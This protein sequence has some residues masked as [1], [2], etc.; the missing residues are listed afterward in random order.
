[1][2][3]PTCLGYKLLSLILSIMIIG[4]TLPAVAFAGDGGGEGAYR[5]DE[6]SVAQQ[7]GQSAGPP[8]AL[9][10]EAYAQPEPVQ[11]YAYTPLPQRASAPA[12]GGAAIALASLLPTPS[13]QERSAVLDAQQALGR[14]GAFSGLSAQEAGKIAEAYDVTAGSLYALEEK[15]LPLGQSLLYAQLADHFGF[16]VDEVLLNCA[17]K[18]DGRAAFSELAKYTQFLHS[19]WHGTEADRA[20][21]QSLLAG[22]SLEQ[23]K[24]AYVAS[25]TLDIPIEELLAKEETA[26]VYPENMTDISRE[27]YRLFSR[28]LGI[29]E[30]AL[31][32]YATTHAKTF[33]RMEALIHNGRLFE[34]QLQDPE[35]SREAYEAYVGAIEADR[36][37]RRA[38][39][40][41]EQAEA[42][43]ASKAEM[44]GM[45]F[46]QAEIAAREESRV[47]AMA[48][49]RQGDQGLTGAQPSTA[50]PPPLTQ[51]QNQSQ[52]PGAQTMPLLTAAA[53]AALVDFLL[54]DPYIDD[55]E[56][57][58]NEGQYNVNLSTGSYSLDYVDAVIPGRNGLDLV[59]GRQF[60]SD[61]AYL[62]REIGKHG[63]Y[64]GS[65][66][67][68][69][70]GFLA[71][72]DYGKL[73]P[74][75]DVIYP[76]RAY[77]TYQQAANTYLDVCEPDQYVTVSG[78]TIWYEFFFEITAASSTTLSPNSYSDLTPN[79]HFTDLYGLGNG[80]KFMFS[81]IET[82]GE[83]GYQFLHLA[84]GTVHA[85]D[86]TNY[87]SHLRD[88]H[89]T[90]LYLDTST[91]YSNGAESSFYRLAYKDGKREYFSTSGKLIGVK[92]RF[93]NTIKLVHTRQ[94][95]LPKISITDTLGNL[96]TIY[97]EPI[98]DGHRMR[99]SL[100]Q[101]ELKYEVAEVENL[102][103]D[104]WQLNCFYDQMNNMANNFGY[105]GTYGTTVDI[106]NNKNSTVNHYVQMTNVT[107]NNGEYSSFYT[108]YSNPNGQVRHY[109][110][111]IRGGY[112][113]VFRL[114]KVTTGSP[115]PDM[116]GAMAREVSY[117]YSSQ[118]CMPMQSSPFY[119]YTTTAAEVCFRPPNMA[120]GK[121]STSTA[122]T[123]DVT[124]LVNKEATKT[125]N[126]VLAKVKL[127]DYNAYRLPRKVTERYY[128]SGGSVYREE[129]SM[130]EYDVKGN[131]TASWTPLA[132]GNTANTEHK[133]T[134]A[135]N[136]SYSLPTS[137]TYKQD[138]ST[139]VQETYTLDNTNMKIEYQE[140]R[141][142]GVLKAKT[143][144]GYD[145]YGN[146][147]SKRQYRDDF[148]N[149][150]E[151]AYAYPNGAHLTE[152]KTA[153][154]KNADG[155]TAAGT[156][157]YPAGTVAT[158]TSYDSMGRVASQTD[159]NNL[160]TGFQRD[161]LG[162]VT[163]ATNPDATTKQYN[164]D[165]ANNTVLFTDERGAQL[166]YKYPLN[167]SAGRHNGE[168]VVDVQSGATLQYKRYDELGRLEEEGDPYSK[169][170]YLYDDLSRL[171]QKKTV[172][173]QNA[174]VAQ[175]DYAYNEA[176]NSA[177]QRRVQKTALGETGSP[178]IVTTEYFDKAG[179]AVQAGRFLG[180]TEFL[181]DFGYDY[182]GNL[183]TEKSAFAKDRSLA[184]SGRW[185][186]DYAGRVA[187]TYNADGGVAAN[188]YNALGSLASATDF[189]GTA[190][191][192]AYDDLG[193][194]LEEK[195][196]IEQ[197][198][199]TTYYQVKRYTYDPA[200]NIKREEWTDNP[201]GS[202]NAWGKAEYDYNNRSRLEYVTMYNG[203]VVDNVT[204]YA[205]DAAGN[206][207]SVQAGMSGKNAQDGKTTS[208]TYD[209]FG[210]PLTMTDPLGQT[211]STLYNP[212]GLLTNKTDR[213]GNVFAYDYDGMK[214]AK[215]VTVSGAGAAE[216]IA[217]SY[218]LTGAVKREESTTRGWLAYQYDSLGRLSA[219]SESG[220]A[221]KQYGY[222]KA[223]N[224]ETFLAQAGG[225][226]VLNMAYTYD[227]QG[228]LST[229]KQDGAAVG[230]YGYDA[231]G[232][233]SSLAYANGVTASYAYN[234][235]N[236]LTSV[237]NKQGGT[238]LSS[239]TYSY[240]AD[241]NQ[242]T[243]TDQGNK[244]V[245]YL[246]DGL[247]RLKSEAESTGQGWAY[248]FDRH[249]NRE[250]LTATGPEAYGAVYH[251]DA[252]NRLT[253]EVR[254]QG[255]AAMTT[256][257]GYDA[258]GNQKYWMKSELAPAGLAPQRAS[259]V[260][261]YDALYE[262]DAFNRMTLAYVGGEA[263]RYA[264][265]VDG[266]RQSKE[267][268]G[269][270]VSHVWDGA[271][272]VADMSGG[273]VIASY[274]RGANLLRSN[275]STGQ[276]YYLYNGHGD[277]TGLA[278]SSGALAWKYDYDAFGN[279][280]GT[281]QNG[282][283]GSTD[284]NPFRFA[285]EYL[286][287]ETKTY[288]LRARYYSPT[289][290]RFLTEDTHWNPGNMIYGDHVRRINERQDP[291][292]LNLY[293]YVPDIAA[294]RQSGNLYVYAGSNPIKF[295]DSNGEIFMLVTGGIGALGGAII[296]GGGKIISNVVSGN[297]WN[298]GAGKAALVG[299]G[300]GGAIGLTGG[301]A[302][303]LLA[304]VGTAGGATVLAG[305]GTVMGNLFG[306]GV[307][308]G[309][310]ATVGTAASQGNTTVYI[311]NTINGVTQYVGITNDIARRGAEHLA[312]KG[313]NINPLMTNLSRADARAVEQALI[314]INGLMKNGG[315]LINQINSIAQN[316]PIYAD[317]LKRGYE[318]L[319][320]VGYN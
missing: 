254:T 144:F 131:V 256:A 272:L 118:H 219:A 153:N 56:S 249:G 69:N 221:S 310:V 222:D 205:Y 139:T 239:Y 134:Y 295:V 247:G 78:V 165:Y 243:K 174:T 286:D 200:G 39:K 197:N 293:T 161:L 24:N 141:V 54:L 259:L 193:R 104:Y 274:A 28:D 308:A 22:F 194:P 94:N 9:D 265:R 244:T 186:Y 246:Y 116:Q 227:N 149:Y 191:A 112:R 27:N 311:S 48:A 44:A 180:G 15:G 83:D 73:P 199:G 51:S 50:Q 209:R 123:F 115:S 192:Y 232:N 107:Y 283:G 110:T 150:V 124:G 303:S 263:A 229:V 12:P 273:T 47:Q 113:E 233:R 38:Q 210:K 58:H 276:A 42:A 291:N 226:T 284:S 171:T 301:A 306:I 170:T 163:A 102:S 218:Y 96:V 157:G 79:T 312:T 159:A 204:K 95:S 33:Q 172:D 203:G 220:G 266:L 201:V 85:I 277:V 213:N 158:R 167:K 55:S 75:Y 236:W 262:Y 202:A 189:A 74:C 2:K 282:G 40:E 238:V 19:D 31:V 4:T 294:I 287:L 88:R 105:S 36:Q 129:A 304:T 90:D 237:A 59:I 212:T 151:T 260:P 145:G 302:A 268:A 214:R 6:T 307:A 49:S 315:T 91:E 162:N 195:G 297:T 275:T 109:F 20:L 120:A 269:G 216:Q 1:M 270:T 240:Y 179:R 251:Y 100:P 169:T 68:T 300:V 271:S 208:Y 97:G 18:G 319:K 101:G 61:Q 122:Y 45:G 242:R 80:W 117:T 198:G 76:R 230:T 261:G 82:Y 23:V 223:D 133:T 248:T 29:R 127:V 255:A 187:K 72:G 108:N 155:T 160:T 206:T 183:L 148:T 46:S 65:K 64:P 93:G 178:S 173:S 92:D 34:A 41:T 185:E 14:K 66:Y 16:T 114:D 305:T 30:Q 285:G 21:R 135:Y 138:A 111:E 32:D 184:Y 215:G 146:V 281:T 63:Y 292:G 98:L 26:T 43:A 140:I 13:E 136:A 168:S 267:A 130:A 106:F 125:S 289:T 175:E 8:G 128:D 86:W 84:D 245:T 317:A 298:E 182:V 316:N 278:N 57:Y 10:E 207:L 231:N 234:K 217:Y 53:A 89:T 60:F 181:D 126:N 11:E 132:E 37:G 253:D 280:I 143:G 152:A 121:P 147:T 5:L 156:P 225:A 290:G 188:A 309:G 313:I 320:T 176:Y 196:V 17:G 257:Y 52:G 119:T 77:D 103:H 3:K 25:Q 177:S 164:R 235:A 314:E 99:V 62:Y 154:V 228:R 70:T 296:G 190:T 211:E 142:N 166:R 224:R 71:Y 7:Q 67:Y 299:A 264:Y 137:K 258:N 279:D 318:L 250:T 252:N 87:F 81:S 241:G 288:Y 35:G